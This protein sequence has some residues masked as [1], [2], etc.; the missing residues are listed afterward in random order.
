[1]VSAF[2]YAGRRDA[3]KYARPCRPPQ[4]SWGLQGFHVR[5]RRAFPAKAPCRPGIAAAFNTPLAGI[6]FVIEEMSRTYEARANG[7]VLTAVILSGL[8]ALGLSGSDNYF[9]LAS[10]APTELSPETAR[11]HCPSLAQS[12]GVCKTVS[13]RPK[14]SAWS[15]T[16]SAFQWLPVKMN[17]CLYISALLSC[18][19]SSH[20]KCRTS[21][22]SHSAPS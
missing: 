2:G 7:L 13:S 14:F 15:E 3:V 20:H 6:V 18:T 8:A 21:R 22:K 1:V 10:A 16:Y 17:G 4:T 5:P 11:A 12:T 19:R 9:G